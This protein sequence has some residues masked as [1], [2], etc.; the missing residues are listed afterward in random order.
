MS[1]P[2][3]HDS[4][5]QVRLH[6]SAGGRCFPGAAVRFRDSPA[7]SSG[8]FYD[9][10]PDAEPFGRDSTTQN[11]GMAVGCRMRRRMARILPTRME[12]QALQRCTLSAVPGARTEG[13]RS[14]TVH[15]PAHSIRQP[16]GLARC[17]KTFVAGCHDCDS[18]GCPRA[19]HIRVRRAAAKPRPLASG[20]RAKRALSTGFSRSRKFIRAVLDNWSPHPLD[21]I[22]RAPLRARVSQ[23]M[24]PAK[25]PSTTTRLLQ[26]SPEKCAVFWPKSTDGLLRACSAYWSPQPGMPCLA[27]LDRAFPA[28]FYPIPYGNI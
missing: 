17:D 22:S 19:Q 27:A 25:F 6:D 20:V 3:A 7:A 28:V 24:A 8:N 18:T 9:S 23:S 13:G 26:F 16:S 11:F 21:R 14:S 10:P 5:L 15:L 4:M 1:A 12:D 2:C